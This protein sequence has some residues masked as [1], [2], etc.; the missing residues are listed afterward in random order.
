MK[1]FIS[2]ESTSLN[3][4]ERRRTELFVLM[5]YA[6]TCIFGFAI[7]AAAQDRI[8]N[9]DRDKGTLEVNAH[10]IPL[11]ALLRDIS[12]KTGLKLEL[13]VALSDPVSFDLEPQPFDEAIKHLLG[14]RSYSLNY[15]KTAEGKFLP[16]RLRVMG[17]G[18]GPAKLASGDK[19]RAGMLPEAKE[20]HTITVDK[21]E[22]KEALRDR[23]S[24]VKQVSTSP[25][26]K[27]VRI[28]QVPEDSPLRTLGLEEG[29]VIE[30][31]NGRPIRSFIQFLDALPNGPAT[32]PVIQIM[33]TKDGRHDPVYIRLQ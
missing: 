3:M 8:V 21:S 28:N 1:A 14:G 26:H 30:S 13:N 31:V 33:K 24:L 7:A 29:D 16:S 12:K 11:D 19:K 9:F 10:E 23:A 22:L 27:G 6:A 2:M 5:F 17:M 25:D 32:P 15:E 18:T 20:R 4:T